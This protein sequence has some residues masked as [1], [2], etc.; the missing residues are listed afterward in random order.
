MQAPGNAE[1]NLPQGDAQQP[2]PPPRHERVEI[3]LLP[4]IE[5]PD[6]LYVPPD[7]GTMPPGLL[8]RLQSRRFTQP[9]ELTEEA[10]VAS[11]AS[12]D[13]Q[14]R[15]A[16]IQ[17]LG[18]LG[19]QAP[20]SVLVR[21]LQDDHES[22]R[23]MAAR[24]LGKLPDQAPLGQ[25][26][27]TLHDE[28]WKVRAATAQVLGK[29]GKRVPLAPLI[30]ALQDPD[31]SV[32]AAVVGALGRL[33]NTLAIDPLLGMLKDP[34][35][36]VR[37]MAVF[38]LVS[39]DDA[40]IVT[41]L[42]HA[43][44]DSDPHVREAVESLQEHNTALFSAVIAARNEFASIEDDVGR[45]LAPAV[46]NETFWSPE[47]IE[48]QKGRWI[49]P[50]A[51]K[52]RSSSLP[53]Q[54]DKPFRR[55]N[56]KLTRRVALGGL[57]A[58]VIVGNGLIWA[59]L[60]KQQGKHPESAA[61]NTLDILP[62]GTTLRSYHAHNGGALTIGWSPDSSQLVSGGTDT[63]VQIHDVSSG[64]LLRTYTGHSK[65][66][67][68]VAWS[69]DG[70]TIASAGSDASVHIWQA[71]TGKTIMVYH[72]HTLSVLDLSWSPDSKYIVSSSEDGTVDTWETA[73]G[74]LIQR[75]TGRLK[76][77]ASVAW[78]PDGQKILAVGQNN[79]LWIRDAFSG[80]LEHQESA[81]L[82]SNMLYNILG[83]SVCWSP[84]GQ[85]YAF[86]NRAG[87]VKVFNTATGYP[88]ATYDYIYNENP[89]AAI[90]GALYAAAGSVVYSPDG[91]YLATTNENKTVQ[92]WDSTS[93]RQLFTCHGTSY[94]IFSIAWSP[95][96]KYLAS[97]CWDDPALVLW[98]AG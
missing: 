9:Q 63:T 85:Q 28:H 3:E 36:H 71:D 58:A 30:E 69:P 44:H 59:N 24:T 17:Q 56:P 5:T 47:R 43:L 60:L 7:T 16:A 74:R 64:Q 13:W 22:V 86:S 31:E 25:L 77:V 2:L 45:L 35:W 67:F 1:D 96:G 23:A 40:R 12:S 93:G 8:K 98:K 51:R 33:H 61:S 83:N 27:Q 42:A 80:M 94:Y 76:D 70:R 26:L 49:T 37:E 88:G 52:I 29:L 75:Y 62:L 39:F 89:N 50:V 79:Q 46:Q 91:K 34:D 57:A 21:A 92:V 68:C 20:I 84:N 73:T 95:D 81:A 18:K 32:R 72:G 97:A 55:P 4:I 19:E 66:V 6:L 53:L 87:K 78:S 48:Q 54:P 65:V 14:E 38:S 90:P 41:P 15:S 11:L 10:L 82:N